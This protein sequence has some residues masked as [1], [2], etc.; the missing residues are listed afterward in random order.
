M[1]FSIAPLLIHSDAVPARARAALQAASLLPA[2]RRKSEL[3]SAARVLYLETGL[4]CG[5]AREL[6][7]LENGGSCR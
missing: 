5:D 3:E 4:D 7:G 2:E 6:V 1:G